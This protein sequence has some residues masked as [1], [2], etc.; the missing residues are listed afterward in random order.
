[1]AFGSLILNNLGKPSTRGQNYWSSTTLTTR[2]GS[3]SLL[4]SL[5]PSLMFLQI[6]QTYLSLAMT[7]MS[8]LHTTAKDLLYLLQSETTSIE[9]SRYL[10]EEKSSV[11]QAGR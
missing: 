3:S 9:P 2:P 4:R 10:A 8:T 7:S 5:R 6:S 1:M 11:R